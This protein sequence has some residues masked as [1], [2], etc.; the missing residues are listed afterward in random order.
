MQIKFSHDYP[1][2][3]GQK[4]ARLLHVEMF[5]RE[6]LCE[7]FVEYDTRYHD[8]MAMFPDKDGNCYGHYPLPP[9]RYIV[10]VFLGDKL[11]PFTTVRPYR[12]EKLEYYAD[13]CRKIFDIVIKEDK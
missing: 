3:H 8:M 10:L 12:P 1:K 11:I 5:Y 2:L 7:D 13:H 9:G 6:E 4:K